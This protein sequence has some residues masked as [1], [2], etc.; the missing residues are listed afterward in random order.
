MRLAE[1]VYQEHLFEFA[2]AF[3]L[4]QR[5]LNVNNSFGARMDFAEK[6][7]TTGAL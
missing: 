4:N 3:E 1:F 7:L 2:K 6:H 5:R